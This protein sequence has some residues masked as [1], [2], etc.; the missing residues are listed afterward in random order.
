MLQHR[1]LDRRGGNVAGQDNH[2]DTTFQ[3]C[4]LHR[5][6]SN[7]W[8]LRSGSHIAH[9]LGAIE[10]DLLR[11]RLLEVIRPN[12]CSRDMRGD[13]ENRGAISRAVIEAVEK[14]QRT[15]SG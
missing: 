9:V 2:A 11:A 7:T 3:D 1:M 12:L 4:S 8:Q 6:F 15:R 13:C 5:E 10:E 14:M